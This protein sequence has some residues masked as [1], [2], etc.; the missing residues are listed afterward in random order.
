MIDIRT[1]ELADYDVLRFFYEKAYR[2]G[3][4]LLQPSFFE[5]QFGNSNYGRA[6]IAIENNTIIGHLGCIFADGLTWLTNLFILETHRS[7]P[8]VLSM[9]SKAKSFGLP[10][11][12][13]N[14]SSGI[15]ALYRRLK[16]YRQPNLERYCAIN[17]QF[18]L[19]K[20]EQLIDPLSTVGA[21]SD[22]VLPTG[23]RYWLQPGLLGGA[24]SNGSTAVLQPNCAGVRLVDLKQPAETAERFFEMGY[25]WVDYVTSWNDPIIDQLQA[26]GWQPERDAPVPWY[27]NPVVPGSKSEITVFS[28]IPLPKDFIIK[29]Y[30]S[31]HGRVASL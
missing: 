20:V 9:Y 31:D 24:L 30:H 1:A 10:L 16:W 3:H 11:V 14:A 17:P 26:L 18:S 13:T 29:R 4:P 25:R 23:H 6:I 22:L 19:M 15:I 27:L 12:T 2:L 21:T 8:L 7:G 5:W 28:N